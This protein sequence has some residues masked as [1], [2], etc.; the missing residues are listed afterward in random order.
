MTC[1]IR[2]GL[3]YKREVETKKLRD[4]ID[5]QVLL[6]KE[7]SQ[8]L[9]RDFVNSNTSY[10]E[11]IQRLNSEI[12]ALRSN[13]SVGKNHGDNAK[14]ESENRKADANASR[15][16][17]LLTGEKLDP[18]GSYSE[19]TKANIM[20]ILRMLSSQSDPIQASALMIQFNIPHIKFAYALDK[21]REANVISGATWLSLTPF[22]RAY[23][24]ERGLV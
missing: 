8:K 9:I 7:E 19:E 21:A 23:V 10:E 22:G 11:T 14:L 5:G 1:W 15:A 13:S 3:K 4:E 17:E 12:A 24:V 2:S 18:L 16:F 6:T 20:H